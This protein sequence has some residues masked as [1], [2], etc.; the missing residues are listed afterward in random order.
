[1]TAK[2]AP[3]PACHRDSLSAK[4]PGQV[5]GWLRQVTQPPHIAGPLAHIINTRNIMKRHYIVL[6]ILVSLLIIPSGCATICEDFNNQII[7]WMPYKEADKIIIAKGN[8]VDTLIVNSSLR[9]HTDKIRFGSKC[10]CENSYSLKLSSDSLNIDVLFE[11]SRAVENSVITINNE[12][13]N[14]S[15]KLDSLE[16]N[17]RKYFDL[18]V[19]E[20]QQHLIDKFDKIIISKSIGIIS[21]TKQGYDWIIINDS[22]RNIELSK[23]GIN[24]SD[25]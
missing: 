20:N 6:L 23:I 16:I 5:P 13:L 2:N 10:V 7:N 12:F 8:Q 9:Q 22:K 17:G 19:F 21:I 15:S 14:Y 1:M 3:Y 25:C 4:A 18:I 11:D 24:I